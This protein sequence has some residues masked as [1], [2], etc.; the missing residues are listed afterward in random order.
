MSYAYIPANPRMHGGKRSKIIYLI[1][2]YTANRGDTARGN[3]T[4][5]ARGEGP[6]ASAH[7][8]VDDNEIILSVPEDTVAYSVGGRPQSWHIP[9][10]LRANNFN[11]ISIEMCV[12]ADGRIGDATIARA[13]ALGREICERYGI[14][15]AHILRH[16]DVNGKLCPN[17]NDL[18][19][20]S[21]WAAFKAGIATAS[22]PAEQSAPEETPA[23]A[24]AGDWI[25]GHNY[26]V[27]VGSLR[28]RDGAGLN[29]GIIKSYPRGTVFTLKEIVHLSI[30]TWGR[31]PSG[32]VCLEMR[33]VAYAADRGEY[34]AG[35]TQGPSDGW[36]V[37]HNY[38]VTA[39]SLRVRDGAGLNHAVIKSYPQGTVFTLKEIV[40]LS[41]S[42]WGR[43]P[44]GW[45]CLIMDGEKYV[46]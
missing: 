43:T 31:T 44:S 34:S 11:S 1:Y 30:S 9:Y 39:S 6:I 25:V 5:F 23:L 13:Q 8:F 40:H 42:T 18:L 2:H 46:K 36:E 15:S 45:V 3:C 21:V 16:Y 27:I 4:Y 26:E 19:N 29:H 12:H 41:I 20:D 32:W 28:V 24:P 37:G 10:Y 35:G 14:D 33:G 17:A 38:T 22:V 7:Y